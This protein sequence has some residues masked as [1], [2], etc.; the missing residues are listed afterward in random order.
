MRKIITRPRLEGGREM[1]FWACAGAATTCVL[2]PTPLGPCWELQ[3]ASSS[4]NVPPD[5]AME[6]AHFKGQTRKEIPLFSI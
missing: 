1:E 6:K 2:T 3:E 5:L 4:C